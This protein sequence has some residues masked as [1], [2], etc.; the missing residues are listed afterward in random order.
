[1]AKAQAEKTHCS[2]TLTESGYLAWIRS[3]LRS[4]W[5]RWQPRNDCLKAA[6][7]VYKGP[8]KLQ[9]WEYECAICKKWHIAKSMEVDHY[10]HDAGSIRSI[11]DIGPFV[12]RLYCEVDNLRALCKPC[13]K[14]H[15]LATSKGISMEEAALEK[16]VNE[17][18]KDKNLL[19]YLLT[20]GYDGKSVSNAAK[21]KALVTQILKGENK[22][23]TDGK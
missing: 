19:A 15:T 1:M 2:G 7:R 18:M 13:H 20:Y 4:R 17:R 22:E 11:A 9:K 14:V 10:P 16:A 5:L 6:R 8:N 3:A 12:G 21:R 23:G